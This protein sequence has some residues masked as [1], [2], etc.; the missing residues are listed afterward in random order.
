MSV[1]TGE[2][3]GAWGYGCEANIPLPL[4]PEVPV[5]VGAIDVDGRGRFLQG[6]FDLGGYTRGGAEV[7]GWT[8]ELLP[9]DLQQSDWWLDAGEVWGDVDLVIT[10]FQ[11]PGRFAGRITHFY[12]LATESGAAGELFLEIYSFST[13]QAPS[14]PVPSPCPG[15][16]LHLDED[17]DGEEDGRDLAPPGETDPSFGTRV[18]G[19][20]R[21]V[22]DFC[23][24]GTS[25]PG[26]CKRLDF[27][28]DEPLRQRPKDCRPTPGS[29]R[30][31]QSM[32]AAS[33]APFSGP[34]CEGLPVFS[35]ADGDEESD[36]SD[37]CPNS[38]G[39]VD[40]NGCDAEQFCAVQSLGS[41][42]RA[43]FQNDEPTLKRPGDC[44]RVARECTAAG[45]GAASAGEGADAGPD[46]IV[47]EGTEV[48]LSG[49]VKTSGVTSYQILGWTQLSGPSVDIFEDYWDDTGDARFVAPEVVTEETL[50]FQFEIRI[51]S[52][53]GSSKDT[54]EVRVRDNS[55]D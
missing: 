29:C 34:T 53:H 25:T 21:T 39:A 17:A 36:V 8:R 11:T 55:T 42:K 31:V 49:G 43:D 16:R 28:N 12:E 33:P 5:G 44:Q 2:G 9:S 48:L 1:A 54:L 6:V 45:G 40:R 15:L 46:Q 30:P 13:A 10:D 23:A 27:Q 32:P 50:V 26:L 4:T 41:C 18:D 51:L 19:G 35:D 22:A 47:D 14:G 20:G 24:I 38:T 52:G 37:R 7:A 3:C